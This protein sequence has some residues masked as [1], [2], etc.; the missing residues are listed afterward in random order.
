M[1]IGL[2]ESAAW[3]LVQSELEESRNHRRHTGERPPSGGNQD[4][5]ARVTA[6]AELVEIDGRR[7]V[8]GVSARDGGEK[9]RAYA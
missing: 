2:M 4:V 1:M 8:F 3:T 6:T 9:A 7:L 5:A